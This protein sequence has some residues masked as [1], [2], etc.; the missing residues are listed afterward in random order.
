MSFKVLLTDRLRR[1][2]ASWGL[3]DHIL[4]EVYSRLRDG[5]AERP[6]ASLARIDR[7]WDG[8]ALPVE[9]IDPTN[10]LR[11]YRFLFHVL[12]GQDEESVIVVHGMM[13]LTH[14]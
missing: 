13:H 12:L 10:R 11:V 3:P 5:L 7:P 6:G 4:V 9:I 2:I 1:E 14:G 8:M